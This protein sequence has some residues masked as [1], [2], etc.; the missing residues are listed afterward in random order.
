MLWARRIVDWLAA[1][2]DA[3]AGL[4][5]ADIVMFIVLFVVVLSSSS[6]SSVSIPEISEIEDRGDECRETSIDDTEPRA[7]VTDDKSG[8]ET[9][10][11]AAR[12]GATTVLSC[13]CCGGGGCFSSSEDEPSLSDSMCKVLRKLVDISESVSGPSATAATWSWSIFLTTK[14]HPSRGLPS[15]HKTGILS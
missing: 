15:I 7:E 6:S 9:G 5:I 8:E 10:A 11:V 14:R 4:F 12:D 3:S 1:D 2:A 13:G